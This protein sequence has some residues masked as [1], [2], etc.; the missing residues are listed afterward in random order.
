MFQILVIV[1]LKGFIAPL[2]QKLAGFGTYS[3]SDLSGVGVTLLQTVT[4]WAHDGREPTSIHVHF[5]T[6]ITS[7]SL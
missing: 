5:R 2:K 3:D 7:P 4:L 6:V 1:E